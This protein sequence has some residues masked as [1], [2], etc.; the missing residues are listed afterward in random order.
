[1]FF[2]QNSDILIKNMVEGVFTEVSNW[3]YENPKFPDAYLSRLKSSIL[4]E[5]D[6]ITL[7]GTTK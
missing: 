4:K 1:M 3:F 6:K 7:S 5:A 2:F